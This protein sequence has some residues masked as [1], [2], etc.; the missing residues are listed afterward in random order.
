MK[1]L[2]YDIKLIFVLALTCTKDKV[3]NT[4]IYTLLRIRIKTKLLS[5]LF[6]FTW[7]VFLECSKLI[8]PKKFI[9]TKNVE[10]FQLQAS[11]FQ[12]TFKG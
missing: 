2:S 9:L 7:L 12:M 4:Y 11:G 10:R 5:I 3:N 6:V 8:G 1:K